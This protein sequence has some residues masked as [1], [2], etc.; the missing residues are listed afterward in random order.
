MGTEAVKK[1]IEEYEKSVEMLKDVEG[2]DSSVGFSYE[3]GRLDGMIEALRLIEED[4]E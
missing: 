1:R 3:L 4:V 2:F